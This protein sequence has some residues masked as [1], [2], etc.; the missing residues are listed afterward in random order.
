M[1]RY[2]LPAQRKGETMK[3]VFFVVL[4]CTLTMLLLAFGPAAVDAVRALCEVGR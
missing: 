4:F 3:Y 2:H 1:D